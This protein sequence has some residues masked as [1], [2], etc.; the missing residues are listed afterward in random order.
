MTL[1]RALFLAAFVSAVIGSFVFAVVPADHIEVADKTK[2]F[3]A[4]YVLTVLGLVALPRAARWKLAIALACYGGAIEIIQ[5]LPFVGRDADI[6]DL[7]V[8]CLAIAAALAPSVAQTVRTMPTLT[9]DASFARQ[10]D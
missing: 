4:F 6:K 5:G 1:Y 7:M 9:L 8:D 10:A 3:F 2:H